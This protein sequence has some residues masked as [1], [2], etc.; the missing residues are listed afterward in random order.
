MVS[1]GLMTAIS[2]IVARH[3]GAGDFGKIGQY[4]QQGLWLAVSLGVF[5]F[6]LAQ[7]FVEPLMIF[8]SFDEEF[9]DL[10]IGYVRAVFFGAPAI[11]AFLVLRFT[12]EG[13][14]FVR[15]I[16]LSLIHI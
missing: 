6:L 16:M 1:L 3:Y 10:S 4:T 7:F 2:P 15:P 11:Y 14:G 12:T 5:V 9:R 8:L 13:I